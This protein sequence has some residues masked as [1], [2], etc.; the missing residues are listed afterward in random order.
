MDSLFYKQANGLRAAVR[1]LAGLEASLPDIL[2]D[3]HHHQDLC[4]EGIIF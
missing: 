4:A 3:F 2:H 1:W